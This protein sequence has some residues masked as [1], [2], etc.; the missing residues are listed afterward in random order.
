M[1]PL[2][3]YNTKNESDWFVLCYRPS[4]PPIPT[5]TLTLP[6]TPSHS[7]LLEKQLTPAA[8][9]PACRG[10]PS[11]SFL[12]FLVILHFLLLLNLFSHYPHHLSVSSSWI[13]SRCSTSLLFLLPPS[14]F[15][16]GFIFLSFHQCD[17]WKQLLSP[18]L[19]HITSG[20][21][22]SIQEDS[23]CGFVSVH[24]RSKP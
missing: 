8:S 6:L 21:L 12:H 4:L 13:H 17:V 5:H 24:F 1:W 16:A 11:F 19:A 22:I 15:L 23:G 18:N 14:S 9:H 20:I 10:I 3:N 7:D 2:T